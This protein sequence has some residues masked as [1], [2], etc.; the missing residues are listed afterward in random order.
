MHN[1]QVESICRKYLNLRYQLLPYLYS[2]VR[3][4]TTTGMP[5]MRALWLH[6]ADDPIAVARGDQYLWGR[7]MLVAPVTE[8]GA[9]SR[10]VCLP[11]G[12]WHDFWTTERFE[13]GRE[14]TRSVDLETTPLFVRA[15]AILPLG[16]V[17]QYAD[18]KRDQPL[19]IAVYPGA[20]GS[21]LLYED[22]GR[23]FN[24]RK[25]EWMGIQ[26][27]WNDARR[28][29]GLHLATGSR[30]LFGTRKLRAKLGDATR[31]ITFDGRPV[32]LKF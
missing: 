17:K 2:T 7:D 9:M 20:D 22:D 19:E 18:E 16:P 32:N 13:G 12:S 11:R 8:K 23:S 5:V 31:D 28:T 26:M 27:A 30:M 1:A 6:Y 3:E 29:L 14:I 10:R 15:G 4:G 21:F 24:Y 25:G